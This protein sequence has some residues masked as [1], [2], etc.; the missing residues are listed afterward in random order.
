MSAI[1]KVGRGSGRR[2]TFLLSV[3]CSLSFPSPLNLPLLSRSVGG[4]GAVSSLGPGI[5]G[6]RGWGWL[7]TYQNSCAPSLDFPSL[8]TLAIICHWH[9]DYN[10]QGNQTQSRSRGERRKKEKKSRDGTWLYWQP[11]SCSQPNTHLGDFPV[12]EMFKG[13]EPL[14]RKK[15]K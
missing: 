14:S 9:G 4:G 1:V 7:Q 12:Q 10:S 11:H 15:E 8:L 6:G 3:F 13:T 2:K 5:T